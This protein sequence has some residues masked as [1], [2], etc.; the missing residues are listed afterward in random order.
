M[1]ALTSKPSKSFQMNWKHLWCVGTYSFWECMCCEEKSRTESKENSSSGKMV[2]K[3]RHQFIFKPNKLTSLYTWQLCCFGLCV[4]TKPPVRCHQQNADERIGLS[5]LIVSS[6]LLWR[7]C[8]VAI[9]LKSTMKLEFQRKVFIPISHWGI[10]CSLFLLICVHVLLFSC[11]Y[12]L[13]LNLYTRLFVG[14]HVFRSC[15]ETVYSAFSN[16]SD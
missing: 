15:K 10:P 8:G 4:M 3:Q 5:N 2:N 9:R 7:F 14:N 6:L 1:P 12:T 16:I 13:A 11:M